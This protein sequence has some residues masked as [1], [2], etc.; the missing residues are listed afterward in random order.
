[1]IDEPLLDLLVLG[2]V[3]ARIFPEADIDVRIA[4]LV[5]MAA[6]FAGASRALLASAVFAFETTLQPLGLLPLLGGC[7]GAFFVSSLLMRNTIMTE[8]IARRGVRV[9][10]EYH[11]DFL[12]QVLVRDVMSRNPV[13]LRSNQTLGEVRAWLG[14][15]APGTRHQGF[16]VLDPESGLIVGVLTRRNLLDTE[17]SDDKKLADAIPRFPR[18]V[19]DDLTLRAAADHMVNHDIGRL[20]VVRR[21]QPGKVIGMITRSDLLGAHRRRLVESRQA[22][23]HLRW[24]GDRS[25]RGTAGADGNGSASVDA[26]VT[27]G[28][29]HH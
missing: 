24:W 28:V 27:G 29:N 26:G 20:P 25:R 13:A 2:W 11:A 22:S 21:D 7:T 17:Q 14:S 5:G 3:A 10:A 19:Y 18:V 1:M 15:R 16:P 4:A 8:K 6:I 12:D 9:P 23:P